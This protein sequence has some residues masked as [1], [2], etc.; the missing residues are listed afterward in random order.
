MRLH[1]QQIDW[2]A[3]RVVKEL[4]SSGQLLVD[5]FDETVAHLRAVMAEEVKRDEALDAEAQAILEQH[6]EEIRAAGGDFHA[7]FLRMRRV[8]AEKKGIV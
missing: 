4:T 3:F 8:L 7:A 5:N 1:P 2:L 6:R